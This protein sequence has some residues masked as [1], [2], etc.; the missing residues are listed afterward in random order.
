MVNQ[1]NEKNEDQAA[2]LR[3]LVDQ[4]QDEK[5]PAEETDLNK[6]ADMEQTDKTE[7]REIDVLNLPP[8]KEVHSKNNKFA[9]IKI[10]GPLVRLLVVLLLILAVL[11]GLYFVWGEELFNLF[12]N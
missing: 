6:Q 2:E 5:L 8:R 4:I 1:M 9:H 12:E 10:S 11:T 3:K 7:D